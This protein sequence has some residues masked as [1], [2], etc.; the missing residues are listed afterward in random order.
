VTAES[1]P[2]WDS[3]A[4][5][6]TLKRGT[7]CADCSTGRIVTDRPDLLERMEAGNF[8]YALR[9]TRQDW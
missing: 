1:T 7:A 2:S 4:E 3:S 6:I 8:S 9:P 5:E